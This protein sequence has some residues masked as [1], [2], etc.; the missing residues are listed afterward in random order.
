MLEKKRAIKQLVSKDANFQEIRQI[1]GNDGKLIHSYGPGF[2]I[3]NVNGKLDAVEI[4]PSD[5]WHLEYLFSEGNV[6]I[7]LEYRKGMG[8][9]VL[10]FKDVGLVGRTEITT[11]GTVHYLE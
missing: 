3:V 1:L 5:D 2:K 4:G 9:D 10:R 11:N 8:A 6:V 7:S